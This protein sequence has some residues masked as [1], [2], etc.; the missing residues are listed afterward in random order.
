M[1][2]LRVDQI[3]GLLPDLDELR[4][5]IDRVVGVSTSDPERAWTASGE[6]GTVGQRL[7][8]AAGLEAGL[9]QLVEQVREHAALIFGNAVKAIRALEVGDGAGA[10]EA[11]LASAELEEGKRR[12][13]RAEAYALAAYD[14][15]RGL[16]DRRPA[17]Q[18]L[19]RAARVA[20]EMGRF[21]RGWS[22]Y[23]AAYR[24]ARD[25]GD[26]G[27]AAATAIGSGNVALYRGHWQ[28]AREWYLKAFAVIGEDGAPR[29]ERWQLYQNLSITDRRLGDLAASR[30]WLEKAEAAASPEDAEAAADIRNGYAQ[31]FMASGETAAAEEAYRQALEAAQRPVLVVGILH[32]LGECLLGQGRVLEAEE[33]AR[34]AEEKAIACGVVFKL[35]EVYRLLG[36]VADRRGHDD[37]FVFYERALDL[38]QER[39][40][41]EF[42]RAQTLDAYA[43]L[44]LRRGEPAS[45]HARLLEAESIY[46]RAGKEEELGK[47][48]DDLAAF[49]TGDSA[50]G[51]APGENDTG[52][53]D[54]T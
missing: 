27:G 41:P 4:P 8:Q 12:L 50:A 14:V 40:L 24:L 31:L 13:D 5:L 39:G 52:G 22:R 9:S 1:D 17:V 47:V 20:L 46:R 38:I 15:A 33:C 18:A 45:A 6:L 51:G 25:A 29:P 54:D 23:Q 44:E 32:S 10:A 48:V 42:E 21:D 30:R 28:T 37:A 7:V 3:K 26:S 11:L 16:R 34:K 49:G 43:A 35:P 2:K 19:R 53:N 36:Q